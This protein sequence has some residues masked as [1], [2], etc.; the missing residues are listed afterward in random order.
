MWPSA[1]TCPFPSCSAQT[2]K[3][4]TGPGQ[5]ILARAGVRRPRGKLRIKLL[6]GRGVCVCGGGCARPFSE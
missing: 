1:L 6:G 5:R 3:F 4:S 2:E